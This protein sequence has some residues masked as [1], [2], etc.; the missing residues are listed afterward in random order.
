MQGMFA[1]PQATVLIVD[2]NKINLKVTECL[3]KPLEMTIDTA[4]SGM[5]AIQ[6]VKEKKYDMIFMDYLMPEMDGVEATRQIRELDISYAKDIPIIALTANC[7]E[8]A[9][10]ELVE[11]GLDDFLRKPIDLQQIYAII[12]KWLPKSFFEES[13]E[14]DDVKE[15]EQTLTIEGLDVEQGITQSG[16]LEMYK[17]ILG[18]FYVMIASKA[19]KIEKCLADHMLHD[20]TIE[21]HALKSTAHLIGAIELSERC[22][23]LEQLG[24]AMMEDILIEETPA[25]LELYRSYIDILRPYGKVNEMA[26]EETDN[27]TIIGL[28]KR[29]HTAMDSFDLDEADAAMLELEKYQLPENCLEQMEML[30]VY[31]ADVA[32]Q[33]V[34]NTTK[35]MIKMLE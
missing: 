15:T 1:I 34:M 22:S 24:K 28:L 7:E 3:L 6:M 9:S 14:S 17:E 32:M 18:D 11:Q 30:R 4:E 10:K 12:R 35:R 21:V 25:M 31:I 27:A 33:D 23:H 16:G 2:D 20:Y 26:K 19:T 13:T 8:E 29:I 5:R